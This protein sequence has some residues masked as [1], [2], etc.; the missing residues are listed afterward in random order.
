MRFCLSA[1]CNA[2]Q[3]PQH[4]IASC[5]VYLSEGVGGPTVVTNQTLS[6]QGLASY[7][8]LLHPKE[9]RLACFDATFLHGSD[10]AVLCLL[11][12]IC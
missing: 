3:C 5:I 1:Q 7:G 4:P 11:D 6:S 2:T 9:N 12:V 8:F 10:E